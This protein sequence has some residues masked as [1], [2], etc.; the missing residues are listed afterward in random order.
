LFKGK[1]YRWTDGW[2]DDRRDMI[3]IVHLSLQ[4][5]KNEKLGHHVLLSLNF[6]PT[7]LYGMFQIKAWPTPF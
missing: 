4:S 7:D 6:T 2:T 1:V 3:T 5:P